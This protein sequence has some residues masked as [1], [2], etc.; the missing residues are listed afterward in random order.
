MSEQKKRPPCCNRG[1]HSIVVITNTTK[2][3]IDIF[4]PLCS[5]CYHAGRGIGTY[6]PGV[7]PIKKDYCENIDGR[8]EYKCTTTILG[9]YMNDLDHKDGDHYNNIEENMQTLCACC[10]RHKSK[11]NKDLN[12]F[13]RKVAKVL[14]NID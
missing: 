9:T 4:R 14:Y 5:R 10:H 3:G 7:S 11:Q 6:A 12:K 2:T 1:C 8:L 13:K